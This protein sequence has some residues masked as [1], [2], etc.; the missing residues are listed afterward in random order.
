MVA[1]GRWDGVKWCWRENI[2]IDRNSVNKLVEWKKL[3][4]IREI[5][6]GLIWLKQEKRRWQVVGGNCQNSLGQDQDFV[7]ILQSLEFIQ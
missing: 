4:Y 5:A 7:A 3:D 1:G 2:S 6:N